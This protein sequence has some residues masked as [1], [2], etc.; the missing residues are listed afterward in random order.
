MTTAEQ[1]DRRI[2]AIAESG[3]GRG[4]TFYQPRNLAFWVYAV[5]VGAGI[6]D[7]GTKVTT[8]SAAYGP[9]L[10]VAIVLFGLYGALF[11]WF[12]HRIDRY[13]RQPAGIVIAAFLWGGFAATWTMAAPANDALRALYAKAWGQAWALDWGAGLAAPFT[14]EIAKGLGLILLIALA[15]RL[16]R[17]A[18]DGFVLGAFLGLGFQ[19]I[20][21]IAYAMSSAAS[22]FGA[23]QIAAEASTIWLRMIVGVAAHILYSAV[24]CAGVVYLL[25]RP[26]Q[27]RRAGRGLALMVAAMLLHGLWDSG[28]ALV[29]GNGVLLFPVW[30]GLILI[31]LILVVKVFDTTV[32]QERQF[33]RDILGPE[34]GSGV[35]TQE[36]LDAVCG[37]R[38]ARRSYRRAATSRSGRRH[39]GY[40]LDAAADLADELAIS[41]GVSG[42]RVQFARRE[43]TRLREHRPPP[44]RDAVAA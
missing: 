19:I 3:W 25:G 22:R 15:P 33:L 44:S 41:G 11:W 9:A 1:Q 18:F 34:V 7:F 43:I 28:G 16:I 10:A 4:F 21:D 8:Q 42:P 37:D 24:F 40:I 27:P 32:T 26:A 14:E 12:T 30:G 23:D 20:E 31:A 17:T 2:H 6:A 29:R 39:R 5:L 38:R 35:L 36:E 13:A